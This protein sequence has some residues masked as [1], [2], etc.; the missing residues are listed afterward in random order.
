MPRERSRTD[1]SLWGSDDELDLVWAEAVLPPSVPPAA[2]RSGALL[3]ALGGLSLRSD[4]AVGGGGACRPP[5][6][7]APARPPPPQHSVASRRALGN[8]AALRGELDHLLARFCALEEQA[9][10]AIG[11]ADRPS[12]AR[13]KTALAL[14]HGEVETFQ[15]SGLGSVLVGPLRSGKE[16]A[17]QQ[18]KQLN[19]NVD[20]LAAQTRRI[21]LDVS[22][23]LCRASTP[24]TAADSQPP[25]RLD[26]D[27]PP[28]RQ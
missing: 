24:A 15:D 20:D 22:V 21:Y 12:L 26:A 10:V 27:L 5:P 11:R 28:R 13:T 14:L 23:G 1:S 25:G 3:D 18:R 7:A 16:E 17:R 8:L 2:A 9:Q 4:A 19:A 6:P